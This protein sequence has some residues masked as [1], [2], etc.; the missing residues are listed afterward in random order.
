MSA[1]NLSA[2]NLKCFMLGRIVDV[3]EYDVYALGLCACYV[4]CTDLCSW[5]VFKQRMIF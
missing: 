3:I 4:V 5:K 2:V 1:A